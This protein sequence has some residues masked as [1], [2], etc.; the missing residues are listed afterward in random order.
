MV[1]LSTEGKFCG[2]CKT[3]VHLTCEPAAMCESCG[4]SFEGY[5]AARRDPLAD[6]LIPPALRSTGSGGAALAVFLGAGL[7]LLGFIVWLWFQYMG[8]GRGK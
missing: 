7:V 2:R 3:V 6:A 4:Q 1:I 8:A 5:E